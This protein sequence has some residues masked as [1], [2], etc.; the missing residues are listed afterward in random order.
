MLK[1]NWNCRLHLF[2]SYYLNFPIKTGTHL[3]AHTHTFPAQC[4]PLKLSTSLAELSLNVKIEKLIIIGQVRMSFCLNSIDPLLTTNCRLGIDLT[5][6]STS[7]FS[8][9][10]F[11]NG[12]NISRRRSWTRTASPTLSSIVITWWQFY[13]TLCLPTLP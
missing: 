3:Y 7:G 10:S 1:L 6:R 9:H 8:Q 2:I 11:S 4:S 5:R 13:T 12:L